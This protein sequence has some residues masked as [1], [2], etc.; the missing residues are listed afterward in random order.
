MFAGARLK[1]WFVFCAP[2]TQHDKLL[3]LLAKTTHNTFD[4][5]YN[6]TKDIQSII[7]EAKEIETK[8][9]HFFDY[10]LVMDDLDRAFKELLREINLL[11]K[12]SQ[13][14]PKIWLK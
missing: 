12:E 6:P 10:V 9:G 14:I 8:F 13:W 3:K 2:P 11:E 5:N 7:E 1:P 4:A